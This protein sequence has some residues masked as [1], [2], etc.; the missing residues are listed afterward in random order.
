MCGRSNGAWW[1]L[2]SGRFLGRLLCCF[3]CCAL[4]TISSPIFSLTESERLNSI[5]LKL[6]S[7]T[8]K[9][10]ALEKELLTWQNSFER[11]DKR[12][13]E[14]RTE[15]AGLR[16]E[17]SGLR[18]ELESSVGRSKRAEQRAVELSSLLAKSEEKVASLSESFENTVKPF[19]LAAETAQRRSRISGLAAKIGIPAAFLLGVVLGSL[20]F[21]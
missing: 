11:S 8:K 19:R 14:L 1:R 9:S 4:L 13:S 3:L 7:L 10:A 2:R 18:Q 6:I 16:S 17:L 5:E 21:R 20:A 15:L 12:A